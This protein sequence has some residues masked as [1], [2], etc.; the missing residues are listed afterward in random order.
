[1]TQWAK[2]ES[3]CIDKGVK[4]GEG[5]QIWHFSHIRENVIIGCHCIL[6]QNVYVDS[7]VQIGDRVKIQNNVSVYKNVII[8]DDVF[9]GPSVVFTNVRNPRAF[10]E[11]KHEFE[12]TLIQKGVSLGANST[13]VC[14][15]SIGQYAFVGAGAVVCEDLASFSLAVGNPAKQIGW[16]SRYGKR[17]K[18][19][20]KGRGTFQCEYTKDL[21]E[22]EGDRLRLVKDKGSNFI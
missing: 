21:Y 1:M 4:I 22:L 5:T 6:G 20:L 7:G 13:I 19:P 14:S 3:V 8:E 12:K 2:H 18:L 11:R 10:I 16:M 15:V 17:I 9:C